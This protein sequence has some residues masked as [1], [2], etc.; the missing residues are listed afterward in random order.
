[1]SLDEVPEPWR[2]FLKELDELV[3]AQPQFGD[4]PVDLHCTGGF[5]VTMLYGFERT[6][7]ATLE[8]CGHI[9]LDVSRSMTSL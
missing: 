2:G 1:M 6:T 3:A 4:G 5:V 9:S 7:N 8:S